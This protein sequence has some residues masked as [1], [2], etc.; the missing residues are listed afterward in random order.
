MRMDE[1]Q[2]SYRCSMFNGTNRGQPHYDHYQNH[3]RRLTYTKS[4]P[5]DNNCSLY[6]G[7]ELLCVFREL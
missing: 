2:N 5:T 4:I 6:I 1:I 3:M 7:L